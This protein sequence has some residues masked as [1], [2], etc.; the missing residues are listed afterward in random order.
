MDARSDRNAIPLAV[1]LDGTL[2]ATD[3]LWEGLFI[4]LKKNPLYLFLIPVWLAGGPARLKQQIS[5]RIDIDPASLPYR[6]E[7]L[8]RLRSEHHEGRKI[9]L[10]TGTPRKFA[11][12]VAA[13]LG[14]FDRVL[15]TDGPH[16][17]TSGRKRASLVAAYGDGG[18]DY[19]GN[20]R[21]D[22]P[23]FDVAR[24]AIVVA[25][26]RS[27]ARWQAAHGA[28][29]L[30]AP[31]PTRKTFIKMLRVHQWLKNS[32]IA[33]PMVLSHQYFNVGM[34]W[35][36]LLAFVSFSAVASAI[37]IVNDFFDLALDRKHPTKRNRPFASGALSIPFGLG[38]IA[39]LLAIGVAAGSLLPIEFLGVLGG[40]IVVT[41]AYSL[42]FKRML[43]IDVLTLAGLYT[44]RVLAGAAATGVDVSF[45]LLAF[46]IFFF[47]SLALVK[48]FVELRTTAIP[49][50]ER[51]AGRGYRTE[52][53]EIVAQAGMASA[54]SSALVLALYM[55]STAVRELYPHPWVMWPL[56]PIVLYLTMRVWILA[57]RDEM[58]D[59]PVVFIIRDWRSQIVVAIGAVLL[60]AGGWGW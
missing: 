25:P 15:A 38:A 5:A 13:H 9:V 31:K 22:L 55:D 8:D 50:G 53:Q 58:H 4:L 48:R 45:W 10:A 12:A 40:Y 21:H 34:I 17:M 20:S 26:D 2:I 35:D 33:V 16:N 6:A 14:I 27:A 1:D 3:L 30:P 39:T 28:E 18:F 60:V 19:A 36:C 52:D 37:Y 23:V 57:R 44:I 56:A 32:L 51:I 7:L 29:T 54:F 41:T 46:S 24:E 49:P 11:E 43:L 47:L 59:D 42:S